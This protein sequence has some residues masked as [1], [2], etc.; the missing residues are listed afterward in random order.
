[1]DGRY[2]PWQSVEED[3]SPAALLFM[4]VVLVLTILLRENNGI[5]DVV[6]ISVIFGSYILL[7]SVNDYRVIK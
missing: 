1:M 6:A 4:K 2:V 5:L 3:L 7:V